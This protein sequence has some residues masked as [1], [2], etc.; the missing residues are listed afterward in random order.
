[1]AKRTTI[2][3]MA[4][5]LPDFERRLREAVSHYWVTLASQASKQRSGR[6]DRGRRADVTGGKQMDGFSQLIRWTLKEVGVPEA[7]VFT[8]EKLEVPGYFRATKKWDMVVV[9]K[10]HL[11]AAL[12]FKSHRGPS[13]GN[14]L[15]NRTEESLGNATDLWTAFREGAYGKS[16]PRPW[17]GWVMLIEDC[18]GSRRPVKIKEPH[19]A[20]FPEFKGSSYAGR[21]SLL[22]RRQVLERHYD[23]AALLLSAES[24]G[25]TG[26]YVEPAT[27]LTMRRFLTGLAAHAAGA[28][29]A[30]A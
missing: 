29:G 28:I 8:T 19:F 27:D 26:H 7:A 15:N 4:M 23:A 5:T 22:M 9:H 1:M 18:D 30:M 14:N 11:I 21:Y 13:F 12:E 10:H 16:G 6:A 20:A 17:L 24:K 2:T 3:C 25:K